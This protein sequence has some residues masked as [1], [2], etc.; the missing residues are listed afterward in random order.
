MLNNIVKDGGYLDGLQEQIN[1]LQLQFSKPAVEISTFNEAGDKLTVK[2][3]VSG[4]Y[5]IVITIYGNGFDVD[6]TVSV[7]TADNVTVK[8]TYLYS[9][10]TILVVIIEPNQVQVGNPPQWVNTNWVVNQVF[11]A[12]LEGNGNVLYATV[13][14]AAR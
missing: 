2:A 12:E 9:S 13:D 3:N 11:S 8:N 5:A 14:I 6:S 10:N 4:N 7:R 1:N